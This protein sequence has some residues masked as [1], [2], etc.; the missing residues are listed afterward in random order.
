MAG[1]HHH[2]QQ[3]QHSSSTAAATQQLCHPTTHHPSLLSLRYETTWLTSYDDGSG[4]TAETSVQYLYSVYWALTTLTTVG[5]GDITPANNAERKYTLMTLLI[6]ALVFGYILSSVGEM[7]GSIDKNAAELDNKLGEVKD[8]TRWHKMHPDLAARVRKYSEVFYSRQ[9]AMDEEAIIE[10]LAPS[11]RREVVRHLLRK[12]VKNIPMFSEE[13]CEYASNDAFQLEV[14]PCLKPAVHEDGEVVVSKRSRGDG[15]FFLSKGTIG[16]TSALDRHI[17][18]QITDAGSMFGE[19]VLCDNKPAELS[20]KALTKCESFVLD[21]KDLFKVL[22]KFPTAR[23]EL[24]EFVFED[25]IRHKMLR[26]WAFRMVFG[27]LKRRDERIA[28]AL[29]L[30]VAWMRH[31]IVL[32]QRQ[33]L[34]GGEEFLRR[35]M[36]GLFGNDASLE[37]ARGSARGSATATATLPLLAPAPV[38][39]PAPIAAKGAVGKALSALEDE[40]DKL[41][42]R[43]QQLQQQIGSVE[44]ELQKLVGALSSGS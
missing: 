34:V 41:A 44:A 42:R 30:Q 28:A 39:P 29:R 33:K 13:F 15:V 43:D 31:D 21:R 35:L 26:Y 27:E 24:A 23:R 37:S 16:A 7:M 8:F 3:Q 1:T 14:H 17:L 32:L 4:V 6:G 22:D 9:S 20:Y 18:Y 36:P 38:L 40:K 5:Y 11:L 19:H 2:H 12:T 25:F 10:N